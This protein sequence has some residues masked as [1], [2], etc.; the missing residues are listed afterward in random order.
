MSPARKRLKEK[1]KTSLDL[2]DPM[3]DQILELADKYGV[4]KGY[5]IRLCI[6][7]AI[8][9][10]AA[11]LE[12]RMFPT[13][14][15]KG[16]KALPT[17]V[18]APSAIPEESRLQAPPLVDF[19][20]DPEESQFDFEEPFVESESERVQEPWWKGRNFQDDLLAQTSAQTVSVPDEPEA[21]E[22]TQ[23]PPSPTRR[24][25]RG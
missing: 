3:S 16:K 8:D 25:R 1:P 14:P 21:P 4:A 12:T 15:I 19:A 24:R 7:L 20:Q 9:E 2:S 23:E 17:K 13:D 22:P 18:V 10:V 11:Q 5:L 6:D